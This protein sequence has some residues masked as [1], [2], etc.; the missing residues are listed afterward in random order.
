MALEGKT[1]EDYQ[2]AIRKFCSDNPE[3]TIY[4]A[5]EISHPGISDLDFVVVDGFP[6]VSPEVE[7]F[8]MGGS[9][10]VMPRSCMPRIGTIEN[11]KLQLVQGV[12][13]IKGSMHCWLCASYI[14]VTIV[15]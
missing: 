2:D 11:F 15:I 9:V 13:D 4:L 6:V 3:L 10:I 5:G 14:C 7:E 1:Y 8:L 12:L